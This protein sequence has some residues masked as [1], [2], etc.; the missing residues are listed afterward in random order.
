MNAVVERTLERMRLP[1]FLVIGAMKAGTTSLCSDLEAIP[2]VFFPT[3]KEPHTLCL[4]SVLTPGG[5]RRY[6][7]LF[8]AACDNQRCGEGSTGYTKVPLHR[9]VPRRAKSVLGGQLRLVY[10][11]WEPVSRAIS[12]HY[13]MYRSGDAPR[14]FENA[15]RS[16][17]LIAEC[18]RYARQLEPWL[19]VF[20]R[21]N[22]HV[23]RF[24]T[25]IHS[26]D[27]VVGGVC[28]FLEVEPLLQG[29]SLAPL[30][31]RGDDQVM[32]PMILRHCT[33]SFTGSQWSKR[34]VHPFRAPG[35][36]GSA[37]KQYSYKHAPS[38]PDPPSI[39]LIDEMIEQLDEDAARLPLLL[40]EKEPYWDLVRVRQSFV[41]SYQEVGSC[42]QV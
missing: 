21:D 3:V 36:F 39:E 38:R 5:R 12:H 14:S 11:G 10:I 37:S 2:G 27:E 29:V 8:R 19:D 24:E 20:G 41:D 13:H 31:N 28:R 32:A 4:D 18:S 30:K 7:A 22:L 1:D 17:P 35:G 9:G 16:N 23:V 25:Y 42:H 40:G 15:Y 26:R 33:R 34:V 6:A